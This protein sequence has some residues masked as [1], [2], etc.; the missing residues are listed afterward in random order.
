M[1]RLAPAAVLCLVAAAGCGDPL[2]PL[3]ADGAPQEFVFR[4]EGFL[5]YS[6]TARVAGDTLQVRTV[7]QL[8]RGVVDTTTRRVPSAAEWRAFWDAV[9]AA[10][11]ARWPAKCG[12]NG[13]RDGGGFSFVLAWADTRRSGQYINAAPTAAGGCSEADYA[14]AE[15]F[16]G[17]VRALTGPSPFAAVRA[18]RGGAP[19]P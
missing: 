7:G 18:G 17:A 1:R 13:E 3:P 16:L 6:T 19:A 14:A 12:D 2:A 4:T 5:A 11:V 8:P 9:R 15:R 10:G